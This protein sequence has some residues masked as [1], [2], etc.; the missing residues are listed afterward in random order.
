ML[1]SSNYIVFTY[2]IVLIICD[3][4]ESALIDRKKFKKMVE[5]SERYPVLYPAGV[6]PKFQ[7]DPLGAKHNYSN[8]AIFASYY[9]HD[10]NPRKIHKFVGTARLFFTGDIVMGVYPGLDEKSFQLLQSY[11]VVVYRIPMSCKN[12]EFGLCRYDVPE[13]ELVPPAQLR[14]YLYQMWASLY[15]ESSNIL[16]ADARDVIFQSNPFMYRRN[17]WKGADIITF[18]ESHPN[19]VIS[20]CPFNSGWIEQCYGKK[21]LQSVGRNV[22][23]CSGTTM[24]TR[25]GILVYVS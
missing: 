20:R 8:N 3:I 7:L 19:K 22:V 25:N 14:Y 10:L 24:G 13:M 15:S 5:F 12:N 1:G 4:G 17:E 18:L 9:S 11:N 6:L 23:S 16:L 21:A 2:I